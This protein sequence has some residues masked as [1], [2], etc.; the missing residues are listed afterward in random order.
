M[1]MEDGLNDGRVGIIFFGKFMEELPLLE[2]ISASWLKIYN[3]CHQNVELVLTSPP[4]MRSVN[5]ELSVNCRSCCTG[6][7]AEGKQHRLAGC[8]RVRDM[9]PR[10]YFRSRYTSS[11]IDVSTKMKPDVTAICSSS[12]EAFQSDEI[13]ATQGAKLNFFGNQTWNVVKGCPPEMISRTLK[14]HNLGG[15]PGQLAGSISL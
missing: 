3:H 2:L 14:V 12:S 8:L 6:R 11:F 10:V 13:H 5:V 9:V 1:V 4:E 15:Q 7:R